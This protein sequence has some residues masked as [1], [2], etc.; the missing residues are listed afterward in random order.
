[1]KLRLKTLAVVV[2]CA[3]VHVVAQQSADVGIGYAKTSVNTTVFRANSLTTHDGV[4]Y[5][6]YY[7]EEERLVLAKRAIGSD[8]WTT[9]VSRY[10]GKC[11]DAHNSISIAVDGD[12]YLHVSWDH[13]GHPL[14]YAMSVEPG[15]LTLGEKRQMIGEQE[16]KVTYPEFYNIGDGDLLFAYRDGSSG[17]GNLVLNRYDCKSRMWSRIHSVLIDGEGKRNAYWQMTVDVHG[18]IHVAWVWR[19]TWMVET[20]HDLC[21]AYSRDGGQT[22]LKTDGTKYD[23]PITADNAEYAWRIPQNSELINQS[24]MSADNNGHPFITTYWR[25]EGS[26]VPQ[27]RIVW[28][29]G[30]QWQMKQVM[31][32]TTPFTLSGGG[33]KM[34]PI[35]RPRMAVRQNGKRYEGYY[36]FRDAD[37]RGGRVS[38]AYSKDIKKGKWK[39]MDLTDY[40]VGAWEPS[41]D[42]KLW[43]EEGELDLFVQTTYQGDGEKTVDARGEMVRVVRCR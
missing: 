42:I 22:W 6:A 33:T 8:R 29:D 9:H 20:N 11:S 16:N 2:V 34:I 4:Q 37:E 40:N 38:V 36:I 13:H 5:T 26:N 15:S 24:G 21:Y 41:Y 1:M 19:E 3:F 14:R 10:K 12:G 35:S 7:D 18:T 43:N 30:R 31:E 39:I 17:N 25:D 27:Y 32:R 23:L 28:Y